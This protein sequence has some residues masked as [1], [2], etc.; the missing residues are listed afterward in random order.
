[1]KK[2]IFFFCILAIAQLSYAQKGSVH[3]LLNKLASEKNDNTRIDLINNFISNTAEVDPILDL[4]NSQL[5]LLDA[6]KR[7]DKVSEAIAL[8]NIAY[9]Y[10]AFGNTEKVLLM[11]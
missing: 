9:D 5:I 11:I 7:K 1:M 6:Q 4:K 8:S 3:D 2:T 10:R